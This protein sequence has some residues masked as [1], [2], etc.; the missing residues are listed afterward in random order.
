MSQTNSPS[1]R[2]PYGL[3]R[4]CYAWDVSRSTYY[5]RQKKLTEVE[6]SERGKPGPK[7][8]SKKTSGS[9]LWSSG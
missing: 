6:G 2:S 3:K 4:V 1:V 8:V 9:I 5:S 7:S